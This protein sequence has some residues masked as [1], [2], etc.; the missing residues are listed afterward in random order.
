MLT[1]RLRGK[2]NSLFVFLIRGGCRRSH[3]P[4]VPAVMFRC[5]TRGAE[6]GI[7]A[8]EIMLIWLER[9]ADVIHVFGFL[10]KKKKKDSL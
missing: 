5:G 6:F 7:I 2:L 8:N 3:P 1:N 9:T 4:S 10:P